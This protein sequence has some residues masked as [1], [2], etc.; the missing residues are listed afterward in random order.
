L[1]W[2]YPAITASIFAGVIL[3]TWLKIR[4]LHGQCSFRYDQPGT[5]DPDALPG[6]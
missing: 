1:G 6:G 2:Q 4:R 5:A 3:Q